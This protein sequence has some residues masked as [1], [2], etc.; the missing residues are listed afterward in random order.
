MEGR[1]EKR[2]KNQK[3]K[4]KKKINGTNWIKKL[5]APKQGARGKCRKYEV[6]SRRACKKQTN[7]L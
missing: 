3:E 7:L 1:G 6:E 2:E 5:T 4:K